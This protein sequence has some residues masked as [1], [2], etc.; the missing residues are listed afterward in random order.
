MDGCTRHGSDDGW[1]IGRSTRIECPP[2]DDDDG[3][4]N[5]KHVS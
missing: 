5:Y 3:Y 2:G 1:R 4:N